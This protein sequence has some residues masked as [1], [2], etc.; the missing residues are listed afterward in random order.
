MSKE[1]MSIILKIKFLRLGQIS[2]SGKG[3]LIFSDMGG[4]VLLLEVEAK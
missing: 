3:R 4:K 2:S 1:E